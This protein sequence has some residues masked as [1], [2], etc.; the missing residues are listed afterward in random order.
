MNELFPPVRIGLMGRFFFWGVKAR[1]D[2][3]MMMMT[4]RFSS[5]QEQPLVPPQFLHT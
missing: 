5:S 2:T 3:T 4:V 1:G